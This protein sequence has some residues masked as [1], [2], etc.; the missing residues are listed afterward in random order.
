MGFTEAV[1]SFFARYTDFQGRSRRSEFWWSYLGVSLM[2]FAIAIVAGILAAILPLLGV[3]GFAAYV[4]F[5]LACL[6]PSLAISFRRLHD[7]DKSAW[8]LL[9][10]IIPLLGGLILLYFYVQPGTQG[11]NEYGPDPKGGVDTTTFD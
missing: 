10:A 11:P 3:I 5:A 8:W 4:I 7:L 6:I 9:I 2:I 1:Q